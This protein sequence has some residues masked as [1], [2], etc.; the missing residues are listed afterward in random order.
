MKDKICIVTGANAGIGKATV[1]QLVESGIHVVMVVRNEEKGRIALEEIK[2]QTGKDSME[3]MLCDFAS[4]KSIRDFVSEFKKRYKKL[5]ILINNHGLMTNKKRLTDDGF[6]S[7]FGV[8]HL[9]YFLHTTLLLDVIKNTPNARII[10]VSSGAHAAARKFKLDDYNFDKRRFFSF[11]AY[12]DSKLYNIMFTY[13]LADQLKDTGITVNTY[14]PGF[15]KTNFNNYSTAMKIMTFFMRPMARSADKAAETATY[16][17]TSEEV[18]NVTG[19]YFED[20]KEKTTSDLSYDTDL[21]KQLWE[22]S[23]KLT[24]KN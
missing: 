6:E 20:M 14:S 23:E 9:G 8:N 24:K 16:L 12:S 22:V 2:T 4:Q 7:T 19:K 11:S 21:Q 13:Y 17:A 18:A 15:T 1:K 3:I 5:H 10:N